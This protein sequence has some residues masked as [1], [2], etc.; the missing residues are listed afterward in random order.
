MAVFCGSYG[1][2]FL[3]VLVMFGGCLVI[4]E[5]GVGLAA[6]CCGGFKSRLRFR[7]G[8]LGWWVLW[9]FCGGFWLRFFFFFLIFWWLGIMVGGGGGGGGCSYGHG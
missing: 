7:S 9:R 1:G 2:G 5:V 3:V 6:A 8:L 4:R